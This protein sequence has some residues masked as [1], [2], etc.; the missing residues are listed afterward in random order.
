MVKRTK[1][2]YD[3]S[4]EASLKKATLAIAM[5]NGKLLNKNLSVADRN[6]FESQL[7]NLKSLKKNIKTAYEKA[8]ADKF[9]SS[10]DSLIN[11]LGSV[12]PSKRDIESDF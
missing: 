12:N 1:V 6:G 9:K 10:V 7:K 8:I 3:P 4:T 5:I 11:E 2:V